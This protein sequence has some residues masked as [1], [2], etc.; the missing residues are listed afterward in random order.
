VESYGLRSLLFELL[1]TNPK[2]LELVVKTLDVSRFA[3]DLLIR[4]PQLLEDITRD[5][6]FD[7]ARSLAENLHRLDSLGASA[8]NLDP[9]RAYRQRQLVRII[10]RET[11]KL[12][13]PASVSA[14]LSDLAEACLVFTAR[15][16]GDEQVTIV[17][18]GKFGGRDI[19]YGADL[20]VV[21]VGEEN[22]AAQNLVSV[23]AQPTAEGNIWALD[24]RLR[25]EGENGPLVCSL[26]TYQSY[27]ANRAQLWEMQ[28]LTRARAI[29]GPLKNEF[30][31]LAK[32]AWRR[33]SQD[34]ELLVKIDS[35]LERIRRERGSGSD[36]LDLKTGCGGIIE[37]EFLVQALQMRE[38]IWE[39][40]WDGTVGGL[41]ERGLLND[42]EAK[43]LRQSYQL[44]R[45]CES[46]LR[47]YENKAVSTLPTDSGEQQKLAVRLG[48]DSFENFRRD[49]VDARDTVHALYE[50]KIKAPA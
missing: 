31:E 4:R 13:T 17:A 48:Y 46:G 19:G 15:L 37:A 43:Q 27:Y 32:A 24:T 9:I 22:R 33:A 29:S 41:C 49:Y 6:T 44:L 39:P 47:R 28:A 36:F 50:R 35:M 25:P 1:V 23:M 7:E 45:Q 18:L 21:F 14:E 16:V 20:D 11:V 5:P 42:A 40:N 38:N 26:Q 8:N 34:P 3:G 30:M 2:L 10:L 12:A